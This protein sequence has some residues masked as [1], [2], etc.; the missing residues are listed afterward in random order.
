MSKIFQLARTFLYVRKFLNVIIVV[1][2]LSCLLLTPKALAHSPLTPEDNES[3]AT[4]TLVPDPTKSW[5]I[6]GE[7]HEG[8]EAQ[9]YRF[10][11]TE[12]QRIHI[13]LFKSTSPEDKD[14]LPG[15]VL[16]GPSINT[17]GAVPEYVEI[18]SEANTFVVEGKQPAQATYEPFSPS[19]FF[20]LADL[21]L[22]APTSG[23]YY[24]AVYESYRGGHYG[25]AIGDRESYTLTEWILIPINLIFVYQ[26]EGQN[27]AFIFVPMIATLA[28]G[29]VLIVWRQRS[30]ATHRTLFSWL[31][32]LT[33]LLFLGTGATM[34][35][36]MF[37]SL[38]QA[39]LTSEVVITLILALIPI[40][41]GI[42]AVR[43]CLKPERKTNLRM[44]LYLVVLGVVA[45][46]AWAGLF[47]GPTLAI[48][49]SVLPS[50]LANREF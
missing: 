42:A 47:V 15:L 43:L 3:L 26:W 19:T 31:G 17:Q 16:M 49:A 13:M 28:I 29:I 35:V 10:N 24:T 22:D 46:F 11:I 50:G 18:P 7:L 23:T 33:G 14:F 20:L 5:A 6:Y 25:L 21:D 8:G 1:L 36:Q 2:A 41:L 30:K 32:S 48:I 45:L 9:Y 44:R 27:F 4:A 37:V 12:G 38:I 39:P 40:L 34:L